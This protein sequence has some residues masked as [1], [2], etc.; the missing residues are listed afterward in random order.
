[1][2]QRLARFTTS[3]PP[4]SSRWYATFDIPT[5]WCDVRF[6]AEAGGT[7]ARAAEAS[8]SSPTAEVLNVDAELSTMNNKQ[9]VLFQRTLGI[10]GKQEC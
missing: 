4:T 9:C 8:S 6:E 10:F 5:F 2:F 7:E 1:M 3:K